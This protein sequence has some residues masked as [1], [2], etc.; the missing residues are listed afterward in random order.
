[1]AFSVYV[2]KFIIGSP[3]L[4]L[5]SLTSLTCFLSHLPLLPSVHVT[6][7]IKT[8]QE[9]LFQE[10]PSPETR[11]ISFSTLGA[12]GNSVPIVSWFK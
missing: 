2:V 8:V 9:H 12:T 1:M 7:S 10:K 6:H 11:G 5:L 3:S 4:S